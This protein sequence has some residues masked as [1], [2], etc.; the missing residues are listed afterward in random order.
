MPSAYQAHW[1]LVWLSSISSVN[2]RAVKVSYFVDIVSSRTGQIP[3]FT[4]P[5]ALD[6]HLETALNYRVSRQLGQSGLS[7]FVYLSGQTFSTNPL[8]HRR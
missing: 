1:S 3:F 6:F 4:N 5:V 2:K 7:E 8:T